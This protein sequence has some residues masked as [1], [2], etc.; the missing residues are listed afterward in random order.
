MSVIFDDLPRGS[1][2]E[3][4]KLAATLPLTVDEVAC[5][6]LMGGD[7]AEFLCSLSVAGFPEQII[8][9]ENQRLWNEKNEKLWAELQERA[10]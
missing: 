6:Y 8:V 9:M 10:Y 3:I 7:H 4:L 5:Y 1:Q 2:E